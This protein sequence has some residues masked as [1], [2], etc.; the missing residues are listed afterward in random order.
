MTRFFFLARAGAFLAEALDVDVRRVGLRSPLPRFFADFVFNFRV[1]FAAMGR[2][3]FVE[4][5]RIHRTT[6]MSTCTMSQ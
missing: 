2:D 5:G 3:P 4:R 6:A 1:F